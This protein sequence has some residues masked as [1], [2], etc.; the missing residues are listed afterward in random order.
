LGG[1]G[2]GG[3]GWELFILFFA[4]FFAKGLF[5]VFKSIDFNSKNYLKVKTFILKS[6]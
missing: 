2:W 3:W 4:I 6:F 5:N 1:G